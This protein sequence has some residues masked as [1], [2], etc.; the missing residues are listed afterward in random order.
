MASHIQKAAALM[1]R[2]SP[3]ERAELRA[4]ATTTLAALDLLEGNGDVGRQ[5][6]PLHVAGLT[7]RART[8]C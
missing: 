1:H 4:V 8:H 2:L 3:A 5:T 7:R 6:R